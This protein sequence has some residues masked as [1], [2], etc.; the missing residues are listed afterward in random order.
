MFSIAVKSAC[1][2]MLCIC[3][4]KKKEVTPTPGPEPGITLSV[5]GADTEV[6]ICKK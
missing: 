3:G 6:V 1:I 5:D 2:L 4:C